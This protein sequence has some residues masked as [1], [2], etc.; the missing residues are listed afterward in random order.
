LDKLINLAKKI[1]K[2]DIHKLINNVLADFDVQKYIIDLNQDKQL[3]EGKNSLGKVIGV[4]KNTYISKG[5]EY[6]VAGEPINLFDTG[7]F[8]DSFEIRLG[9]KEFYIDANYY[10]GEYSL[11]YEYGEEIIGLSQESKDALSVLLKKRL[12][13]EIKTYLQNP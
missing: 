13:E 4:Y 10:K 6:K 5:G 9:E 2:I 11:V 7:A 3:L 12:L 1:S 8:F